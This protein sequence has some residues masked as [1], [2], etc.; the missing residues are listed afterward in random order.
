MRRSTF[1][2]ATAA[3]VGLLPPV[4]EAQIFKS[5]LSGGQ[6]IPPVSTTGSGTAVVALNSTTNQMTIQSNF[7][8]LV[9]NTSVAHIH[10]CVVQ[11]GNAG[12]ATTTPTFVGFPAGV[13]SGTFNAA[14]NMTQA[15]TWNTA[16]INANGG[17]TAGAQA[18]LIAGANAGRAYFNIHSVMFPAGEIRGNLVRFTFAGNSGLSARTQGAAAALYSVAAGALLLLYIGIHNAW[19]A[20]TWM[21][22]H[23]KK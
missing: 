3:L 8:G 12:V 23:R 11:P 20:A 22:V 13:R 4:A 1:I 5:T 16:F 19:D 10:C 9:S 2:A 7:T 6:E 15:G 18:A 21:A 14:L 17:T